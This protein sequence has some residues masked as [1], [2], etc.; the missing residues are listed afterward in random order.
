MQLYDAFVTLRDR[1]FRKL[2][3]NFPEVETEATDG[4]WPNP[5]PDNRWLQG[6]DRCVKI[7]QC[8]LL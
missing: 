6:Q 3:L 2:L 4:A 8:F 5:S 7:G 1:G